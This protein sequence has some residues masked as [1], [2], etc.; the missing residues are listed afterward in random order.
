MAQVEMKENSDNKKVRS[1]KKSTHVDMTPMV[2]LGFLLITFFMLATTLSKPQ[3]IDLNMPAKSDEKDQQVI[4]ESKA[5]TLILGADD[6]LFYSVG[7]NYEKL[8][9]LDFS[10]AANVEKIIYKRQKEVAAKYGDK[11]QLVILIK[12]MS[13]SKYRNLV[14]ILDEMEITQTKRFSLLE[15]T[16]AD[17]L[18]LYGMAGN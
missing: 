10:Q 12:A 15:F 18:M 8:G 16:E 1:V 17:S 4:P 14:N 13:S 3:T 6:T 2:D 7:S 5:L 11:D 9:F